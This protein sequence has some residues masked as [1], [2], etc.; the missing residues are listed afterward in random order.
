MLI[1][2]GL[3]SGQ[4]QTTHLSKAVNAHDCYRGL[5]LL[6]VLGSPEPQTSIRIKSHVFYARTSRKN[7]KKYNRLWDLGGDKKQ[8]DEN[9]TIRQATMPIDNNGGNM[10]AIA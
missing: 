4:F 7:Q 2:R 6:D 8:K 1:L 9:S 10:Y 3:K 5:Y